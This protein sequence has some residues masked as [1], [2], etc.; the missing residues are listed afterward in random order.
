MRYACQVWGLCDNAACHRILTLQKCALRLITFSAPRSPSNPI[1]SNLGILKFFDLVEFLNI[2]LVHQHFARDLPVDL[3]NTFNLSKVNHSFNTR[4]SSLGLL[5]VSSVN[6]KT[7]GLYSLL[8]LSIQQWNRLQR[9]FPDTNLFE[10]SQ[11][12][13]KHLSRKFYLDNYMV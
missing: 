2:L 7:Y 8:R 12:N 3:L 6:T 11:S 9:S 1:F 13:L 10:I 4:G 5:K